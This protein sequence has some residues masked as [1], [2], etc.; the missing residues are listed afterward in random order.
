VFEDQLHAAASAFSVALNSE[1]LYH[2]H[3]LWR[4]DPIAGHDE[5]RT[6]DQ[7]RRRV[8]F[9]YQICTNTPCL[10]SA[11]RIDSPHLTFVSELMVDRSGRYELS[12][13]RL[14]DWPPRFV[15]E[16]EFRFPGHYRPG[17]PLPAAVTTNDGRPTDPEILAEVERLVA[18]FAA[19][20]TEIR[21][22]TP[23]FGTGHSEAEILDF[24]SRLNMRL[25]DD[26]RAL[27]RTIRE[28]WY[29]LLGVFCVLPLEKVLEYRQTEGP[30]HYAWEGDLFSHD[31]VVMAT[32]P[33]GRVRRVSHN[34]G[35]LEFAWD[36]GGQD[37]A[38]DLDPDDNGTPGQIIQYGHYPSD[39]MIWIASS[40]LHRLRLVVDA[41]RANDGWHA[42][43]TQ[44]WPPDG[45]E[46]S[47]ASPRHEW[48]VDIGANGVQAAIGALDDPSSVQSAALRDVDEIDL[49]ELAPLTNL[50]SISLRDVR[51]LPRQV[52]F[53]MPSDLPVEEISIRA[54]HF[55]LH[56]IP[57]TV[58]NL[59]LADN[60]TPVRIKPLLHSGL[61]RLDLAEAL[62]ADIE[63]LSQQ[64]SVRV[65]ILSPAQWRTLRAAGFEAS[66]LAAAS[67]GDHVTLADAI[68][69]SRWAAPDVPVHREIIRGRL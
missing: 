20:Y 34:D 49:A 3:I 19:R 21:G 10:P 66:T 35:W 33:A 63:C 61:L 69:W 42:L 41:L 38:V 23:D 36:R 62:V 45:L 28:D 8:T 52:S 30:H 64:P 48:V 24:E 44:L 67:L 50:R 32:V 55:D 31:Q 40:V 15:Y 54:A 59:T 16:D 68:E 27:Y 47:P 51:R 22:Q 25:P 60:T 1:A 37:W 43:G 17:T 12:F 65:L 57:R 39:P 46:F 29:G 7:D 18:R 4:S 56:E 2:Q 53:S 26:L 6:L 13:S 11:P 5:Y 14:P 9:D 58:W